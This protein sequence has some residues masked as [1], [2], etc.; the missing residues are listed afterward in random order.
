LACLL[1]DV[2]TTGLSI[3]DGNGEWKREDFFSRSGLERGEDGRG[4]NGVGSFQV[5]GWGQVSGLLAVGR[6]DVS[7]SKR[8]NGRS[9]SGSVNE[10]KDRSKLRK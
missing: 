4:R 9:A 3:G 7:S 6:I 2:L 8:V 10:A 5:G 1:F